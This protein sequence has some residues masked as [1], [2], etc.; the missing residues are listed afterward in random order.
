MEWRDGTGGRGKE[1]Q[2]RAEMGRMRGEDGA[3]GE[4]GKEGGM[5]EGGRSKGGSE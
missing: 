4:E 1:E 3:K 5:S 2:A